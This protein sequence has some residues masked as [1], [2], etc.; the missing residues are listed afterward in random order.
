QSM[1]LTPPDVFSQA[2]LAVPM[3]ILFEAGLLCG[4]MVKKREEEFRGDADGSEP[5]PG[6]Q[7]PVSRP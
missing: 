5:D 6:D 1:V 7:P 2:L 4:S 3:W